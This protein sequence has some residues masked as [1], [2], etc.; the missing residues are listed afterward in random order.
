MSVAAIAIFVF[1]L[2]LQR[3]REYVTLRAQGLQTRELHVL[4][5][6]EAALVAVSGLVTGIAVGSGV[7]FL[8]IQTLRA[9]FILDPPVIFPVGRVAIV[10]AL[11]LAATLV[12]GLGASE[13]LRRLQPAEILREE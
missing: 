10:A 2:M 1:G 8:L 13:V 4:V 5:L 12:S 3:R 7:A 6:V 9:L 11:V